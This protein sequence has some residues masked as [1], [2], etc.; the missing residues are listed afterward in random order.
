MSERVAFSGSRSLSPSWAGLVSRVV[1]GFAGCS[2]AVG[3]CRGADALVSSAAPG[4]RVFRAVGP[5]PGQLVARSV[6]LV[7]WLAASPGSVLVVFVG[8]PCPA[9]VS[10]SARWPGGGSGSWASAALAVGL[11]CRVCVFWCGSGPVALPA[12]WGCWLAG[13]GALAGGWVLAGDSQ[14]SLV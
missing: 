7:R 5:R 8:G 9:G 13:S 10:P 1:A 14:K 4:A 2:L 6:A 12:S 3:C 11:G